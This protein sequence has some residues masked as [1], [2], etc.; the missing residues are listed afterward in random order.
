MKDMIRAGLLALVVLAAGA[1]P[2]LAGEHGEH[3]GEGRIGMV[4]DPLVVKECGACHM[5]F[6]PQFLPAESWTKIMSDLKNHF[7]GNA[8]LDE[9]T[10]KKI[11]AYLTAHAAR[12]F[13]LKAGAEPPLRITELRWFKHEHGGR[14]SS[15]RMLK[16]H[17]AKTLADCKACHRGADKGYY[18][19]D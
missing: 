1:L 11:T 14:R 15:S 5:A 4:K 10:A 17:G 7:G 13:P 6:Q 12:R 3:E 16:R 2:A 19:D 8:T 9:E 18:D